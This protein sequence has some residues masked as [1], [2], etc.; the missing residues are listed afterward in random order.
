M[1]GTTEERLAAVE[2]ALTG[3]D[4]DLEALAEGAATADRVADLESEVEELTDRIAELE[5]ATQALRG[6]VGNVRSVN[7][8]VEQRADR[9]LEAAREARRAV[10]DPEQS[11][12]D[13]TGEAP[14]TGHRGPGVDDATPAADARGGYCEHCDRPIEEASGEAGSSQAGTGEAGRRDV[15]DGAARAGSGDQGTGTARAGS[16][17]PG[18]GTTGAGLGD[19]HRGTTGAGSGP[20]PGLAGRGTDGG[21]DRFRD[22]DD[23]PGLVARIRDLV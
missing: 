21:V 5:A 22:G 7:E 20:G 9:A 18:N 10:G 23:R 2:R 15:H 17:E 8:E 1:D 4:H 6:Y 14:A 12:R 13:V 16:G 11:G 3:G 19:P